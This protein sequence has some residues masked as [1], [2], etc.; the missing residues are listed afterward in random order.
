MRL[1]ML[2]RVT[3]QE[4]AE[5]IGVSRMTISNWETGRAKPTLTIPQVRKLCE[6]LGVKFEDLPDDFGPQPVHETSPF[7]RSP[8]PDEQ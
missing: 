8:S 3:Q 4:L 2:R 6:V 1:R 7:F 5:A